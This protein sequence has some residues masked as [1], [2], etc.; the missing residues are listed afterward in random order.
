VKALREDV[1]KPASWRS[2]LGDPALD[3]RWEQVRL[4]LLAAPAPS[5]DPSL[6]RSCFLFEEAFRRLRA[7]APHLDVAVA[8]GRA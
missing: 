6:I 4:G 5:A 3:A 2:D 8:G 1:A 7:P